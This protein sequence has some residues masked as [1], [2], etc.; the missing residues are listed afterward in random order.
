MSM[1]EINPKPT[2]LMTEEIHREKMKLFGGIEPNLSKM[3][4]D[5][6]AYLKEVRDEHGNLISLNVFK[7]DGTLI[8]F[9][10]KKYLK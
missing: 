5:N 9:V 6:E 3:I 1:E 4:I 10:N 8:Y 7:N 2:K